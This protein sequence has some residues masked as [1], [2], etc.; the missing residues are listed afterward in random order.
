VI[1][2]LVIN[3][4]QAMPDGGIIVIRAEN[5]KFENRERF[6]L[7]LPFGN[8]IKISVKDHGPGITSGI[9]QKVFD[10][11]FTTR[12][13][14]S[15]L[16]L[17]V[18]HSIVSKHGGHVAVYSNPGEITEFIVFL[19]ALS[20][21]FTESGPVSRIQFQAPRQRGRILIMDDEELICE[22]LSGFLE[23]QGHTVVTVRNG[24]DVLR[25]YQ[26]QKFSLVILDLTI[27]GGMG[28]RETIK[29]LREYDSSV[30]AIVSSGYAND[31]M[32]SE[33]A[34]YG[35]YGCLNK[36]YILEDL[37]QLVNRIHADEEQ[38]D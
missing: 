13:A 35:F 19:P 5:F 4:V 32:M 12:T 24:E 28:G 30:K 34:K 16:G 27:P 23:D 38:P 7:P 1:Q 11:F 31:P 6:S 21:R 29:L 10:P 15:G 9:I 33:Y 17:S 22:I 25:E 37:L 14:G 26:R 18:V 36:P 8:Y 20:I 3:A 2:N